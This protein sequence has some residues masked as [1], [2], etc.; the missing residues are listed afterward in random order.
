MEA[1]FPRAACGI[2][3]KRTLATSPL[4]ISNL[5]LILL[6]LLIL[7][8]CQIGVISPLLNRDTDGRTD[9]MGT[10]PLRLI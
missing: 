10:A 4:D 1:P 5:L 3:E 9:D 7:R 2:Q 6:I 8:V